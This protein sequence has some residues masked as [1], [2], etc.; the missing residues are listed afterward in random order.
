V[1]PTFNIYAKKLPYQ[2]KIGYDV[3]RSKEQQMNKK[4]WKPLLQKVDA[5][6]NVGGYFFTCFRTDFT[7][8]QFEN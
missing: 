6:P 1:K 3:P 2:E 7:A 8:L 5:E 4:I